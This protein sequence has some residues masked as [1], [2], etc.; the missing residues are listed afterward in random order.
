MAMTWN[1]LTSSST[2]AGSIANYINTSRITSGADGVAA[3]LLADSE[4][5]IY[6]RLRHWRMLT[7]PLAVTLTQGVDTLTIADITGFLE[8][9]DF[10]YLIGGAPTWMVQKTPSQVYQAWGY[11][12]DGTRVEQPPMIYAFNSTYLQFDAGP[13]QNYSG[14]LTYYKQPEALS[15]SN[16]TNFLTETYPRLVRLACMASACEWAKDNGQ[17]AYDRTYYDVLAD[18]EIQKA[19]MESDRAR[20]GVVNAGVTFGGGDGGYPAYAG[21]W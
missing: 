16:P 3:M 12:G 18:Q 4:S 9:M 5:W 14:Y 21:T 20:R 1:I 10:F 6:R 8:P 7:P 19:Q 11:N 13:D 2:T 17:G 15:A